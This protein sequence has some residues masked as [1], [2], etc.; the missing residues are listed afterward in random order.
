M[1]TLNS[2]QPTSGS[3]NLKLILSAVAS[4]AVVAGAATYFVSNGT[5]SSERTSK[6][7]DLIPEEFSGEFK[8]RSDFAHTLSP[9]YTFDGNFNK[10]NDENGDWTVEFQGIEDYPG[11]FVRRFTLKDD[12]Y[13]VAKKPE[14]VEDNEIQGCVMDY[15]QPGYAL[16]KENM[17]NAKEFDINQLSSDSTQRLNYYCAEDMT[18]GVMETEDFGTLMFCGKRQSNDLS[19]V[20]MG[21]EFVA[22]FNT[23][24]EKVDIKVVTGLQRM[25]Y[26]PEICP[27]G[28][29][30]KSTKR[31]YAEKKNFINVDEWD[32]DPVDNFP[33]LDMRAF[34]VE[35]RERSLA[36]DND[37]MTSIPQSFP[38]APIAIPDRFAQCY[39]AHGAGN[40]SGYRRV[41]RK[42]NLSDHSKQ[43]GKKKWYFYRR[44][45]TKDNTDGGESEKVIK[46]KL[47]LKISNAIEDGKMD[48]A[49][50]LQTESGDNTHFGFWEANNKSALF[51]GNHVNGGFVSYDGVPNGGSCYFMFKGNSINEINATCVNGFFAYHINGNSARP[52]QVGSGFGG[53]GLSGYW[54][55]N[56]EHQINK[57][58][59]INASECIFGHFWETNTG[60]N[61]T[62]YIHAKPSL[63]YA[64]LFCENFTP[65]N[66]PCVLGQDGWSADGF[67]HPTII[68][69]I[70]MGGLVC[71]QSSK[72]GYTIKG[73]YCKI[74]MSAAPHKGSI[75]GNLF[76]R[77]CGAG[78]LGFASGTWWDGGL[79]EDMAGDGIQKSGYCSND[80]NT[81]T[82]SYAP[83]HGN[84]QTA[85]R[86]GIYRLR[87]EQLDYNTFITYR[88]QYYINYAQCGTS[89][90]GI[91]GDQLYVM[92]GNTHYTNK[93]YA[94][95][96][97]AHWMQDDDWEHKF[98]YHTGNAFQLTVMGFWGCERWN[99]CVEMWC[100]NYNA[101]DPNYTGTNS[102]N[103]KTY[104]ND[105]MY[106]DKNVHVY[107]RDVNPFQGTN[108]F[109]GS[110]LKVSIC[111]QRGCDNTTHFTSNGGNVCDHS[112]DW[113]WEHNRFVAAS[114]G[115]VGTLSCRGL[116]YQPGVGNTWN[117]RKAIS[118]GYKYTEANH[119]DMAG[120]NG[121]GIYSGQNPVD[122]FSAS[123]QS[124]M[125]GGFNDNNDFNNAVFN[126]NTS[127]SV[128]SFLGKG[129]QYD[130]YQGYTAPNSSPTFTPVIVNGSGSTTGFSSSD[131]GYTATT[132]DRATFKGR[133]N[134][135]K[136]GK[137]GYSRDTRVVLERGDKRRK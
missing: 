82:P 20:V 123:I 113:N 42:G 104:A 9:N 117:G 46:G 45:G 105:P 68:M 66:G 65:G 121:N 81:T 130:A 11:K 111:R 132:S 49:S 67:K 21:R 19:I 61:H 31:R 87:G 22:H 133:I 64:R 102:W 28:D 53:P 76:E 69:S 57:T 97:G 1:L 99:H 56:M 37:D 131:G 106:F 74:A 5:K 51:L 18:N 39:W 93:K 35:Q 107:S 85:G 43:K 125:Q 58:G 16:F 122:F 36:L 40:Q 12:V 109:G 94:G 47:R 52:W 62:T 72:W 135:G 55:S 41:A 3:K 91:F 95:I 79:V 26:E 89:P 118:E 100:K 38:T 116:E 119:E 126:F 2:E 59:G 14:F 48:P 4:T 27:K 60:T 92:Q 24:P 33:F 137:E 101:L 30:F 13:E 86:N 127:Y 73:N 23:I 103:S 83:Q 63:A 50:K 115:I 136:G 90:S 78:L 96:A 15:K 129:Y 6:F 10:W 77:L 44:D 88:T 8:V 34:K 124:V 112:K 84:R 128:N 54:A 114:D 29:K 80:T 25:P 134:Y 17:L 98:G 75:G 7:L 71:M 110:N 108:P 70:S 32:F 120:S